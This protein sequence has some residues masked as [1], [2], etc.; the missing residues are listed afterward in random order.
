[1]LFSAFRFAA[2]VLA[3]RQ[4]DSQHILNSLDASIEKGQSRKLQGRFLHIIDI[5][6]VPFYKPGTDPNGEHP[7]YAGDGSAGYYG[8][9]KQLLVRR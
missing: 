9:E 2:A 3:E 4:A 5:H 1:M 6:T 7:C 8:A